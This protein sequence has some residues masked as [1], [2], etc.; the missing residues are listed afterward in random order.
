MLD[1]S[2]KW[3]EYPK[4]DNEEGVVAKKKFF[5]RRGK[6]CPNVLQASGTSSTELAITFK[7]S[8]VLCKLNQ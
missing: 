4:G 5:R 3:N 1:A 7:A 6:G 2:H 8:P